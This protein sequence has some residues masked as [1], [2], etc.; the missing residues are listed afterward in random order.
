VKFD[1]RVS[2]NHTTQGENMECPHAQDLF[3]CTEEEQGELCYR[4]RN[5]MMGYLANPDLVS[6]NSLIMS[7]YK[8]LI[9]Y[10]LVSVSCDFIYI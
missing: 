9:V 1:T 7:V 3:T 4:G 10:V 6:E 5:I 2:L 8:P